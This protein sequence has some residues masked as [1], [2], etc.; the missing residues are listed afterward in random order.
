MRKYSFPPSSFLFIWCFYVQVHCAVLIAVL[1]SRCCRSS[2]RSSQYC[3]SIEGSSVLAYVSLSLSHRLAQQKE[4]K[5][6][7][8]KNE[9]EWETLTAPW[10]RSDKWVRRRRVL[11]P[12]TPLMLW[13]C[14]RCRLELV[15][16]THQ[17]VM[18][19]L[20]HFDEAEAEAATKTGASSRAERERESEWNSELPIRFTTDADSCRWCR[21]WCQK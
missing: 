19:L 4:E 7:E 14:Y 9:R 1:I 8:R 2:R 11:L 21:C 3:E 15:F 16:I 18:W 10:A 17:L 6:W 13:P 5:E 12:P 20:S